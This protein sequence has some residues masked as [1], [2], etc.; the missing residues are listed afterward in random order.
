[1]PQRNPFPRVDE[2][3]D[4]LLEQLDPARIRGASFGALGV[5]RDS[6]IHADQCRGREQV[7]CGR[8]HHQRDA[9]AQRVAGEMHGLCAES[10]QDLGDDA[11]HLFAERG[12]RVV[13][14]GHVR[15][16]VAGQ[17]RTED[18]DVGM[19]ACDDIVPRRGGAGEA[20]QED[21]AAVHGSA[22]MRRSTS[23]Q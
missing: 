11:E 16:V 9:R 17:G 1:M 4:A 21:E 6:R 20:V 5:V 19:E 12:R 18:V 10:G 7:G 2:R 14:I 3:L 8:D 22:A 15:G 23:A 13:Q